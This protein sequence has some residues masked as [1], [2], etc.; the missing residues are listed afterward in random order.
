LKVA[1][2]VATVVG[3]G[4]VVVVAAAAA[5]DDDVDD[6]AVDFADDEHVAP[7]SAAATT[8]GIPLRISGPYRFRPVPF[9][10]RLST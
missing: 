8:R 7:M 9:S 4:A 5:D 6:D 1:A 10:D 2:V 3:G